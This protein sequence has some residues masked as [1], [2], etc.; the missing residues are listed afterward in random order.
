MSRTRRKFTAEEK[1]AVALSAIREEQTAAEI[2]RKHRVH[3]SQVTKW[4][5]HAISNLRMLF[6]R[7]TETANHTEREAALFEEIGRLQ[8]E[9]RW[10]QKKS[11]SR[12]L[13]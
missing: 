8:T 10:L 5:E 7:A 6:E 11:Q 9:L 4:K 2:A 3:N 13:T 1:A 12:G